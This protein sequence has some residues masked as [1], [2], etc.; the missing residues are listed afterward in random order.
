ML[1]VTTTRQ[2]DERRRRKVVL[3]SFSLDS[4]LSPMSLDEFRSEHFRKRCVHAKGSG[5]SCASLLPSLDVEQIVE[6]TASDRAFV[7]VKT[8]T[9]DK[10]QSVEVDDARAGAA[11][12]AAGHAVYCRARSDYEERAVG[13]VLDE[14]SFGYGNGS[15]SGRGEAEIFCA[16]EGHSTPF[17]TDFQENFTIQ[18]RGRKRWTLRR[19]DDQPLRARSDHF[20]GDD[21]FEDQ[22]KASTFLEGDDGDDEEATLTMEEGDVLYFP[23][24]TYHRV[25]SLDDHN[26]SLNISLMAPS[27]ADLVC[28]ALRHELLKHRDARK[29]ITTGDEFHGDC[30]AVFKLASN[31]LSHLDPHLLHPPRLLDAEVEEEDEEDDE[32]RGEELVDIEKSLEAKEQQLYDESNN[33]NGGDIEGEVVHFVVNPLASMMWLAEGPVG[34]LNILYGANDELAAPIRQRLL[35]P[36]LLADALQSELRRTDDELTTIPAPSRHNCLRPPGAIPPNLWDADV[37]KR[38]I[39]LLLTLEDL[40]FLVRK[41]T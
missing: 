14:L 7:W 8:S 15:L 24:G 31:L 16:R 2:R 34:V 11:L 18:I 28:G 27:W 40:R 25:E 41:S 39:P 23:A 9:G 26:L 33:N 13:T 30:S 20:Q 4:L 1:L 35:F 22:Y 10:L 37:R 38:W 21:A 29:R 32:D 12:Y 6:E 3:D 17:H 36:P 19:G 5:R